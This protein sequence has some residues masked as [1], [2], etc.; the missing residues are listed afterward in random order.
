[1]FD[2][3]DLQDAFKPHESDIN[4]EFMLTSGQ[5]IEVSTPGVQHIAT[6]KD[7]IGKQA[8]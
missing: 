3:Y 1:M 5:T 2:I 7:I 8:R 4:I 6:I